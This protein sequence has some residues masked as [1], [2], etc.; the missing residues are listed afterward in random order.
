MRRTNALQHE[1]D[2]VEKLDAARGVISAF[3]QGR[4]NDVDAL[5]EVGSVVV[6]VSHDL[7]T[8][9]AELEKR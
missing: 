4:H 1:I 2:A 5:H 7:A 8:R 9:R 3:L 6:N